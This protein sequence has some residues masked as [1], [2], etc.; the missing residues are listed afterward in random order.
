MAREHLFQA[1]L[2]W[3][4]A[5]QGP[6]SSYEAYSR[7]YTVEIAGKPTLTGSA[8]TPYRGD[9]SLPNPEDLL[10][11]SVSA[12]HLLSYLAECARFDIRVLDYADRCTATMTFKD[13][14]MR[15]VEATLRPQVTISDDSDPDKAL[16]LHHDANAVCFIA[17]SVNFPI[18]HE[19]TVTQASRRTS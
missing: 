14:K 5:A 2:T 4:G 18:L 9:G 16:A 19:P 11:A 17:N 8:A 15:I 1:T 13:G 10:L 3:T 6:T 12:C 7:E